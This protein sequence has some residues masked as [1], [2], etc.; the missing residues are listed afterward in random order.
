MFGAA[1][2]DACSLAPLP[3]GQKPPKPTLRGV[4]VAVFGKVIT[5]SKEQSSTSYE[6]G[7]VRTSYEAT[8]R[9]W[10]VY[11]GRV[12]RTIHI[13]YTTTD[14]GTCGISFTE[15]EVAALLL[16]GSSPFEVQM[17]S[18]VPLGYLKRAT[19]G[20]WRRPQQP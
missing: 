17:G 20:R 4:D 19:D 1:A 12:A 14:G 11:K 2:A 6:G 10:R 15:G 8:V 5:I 13:R 16:N 18:R 9:V 3:P 7:P